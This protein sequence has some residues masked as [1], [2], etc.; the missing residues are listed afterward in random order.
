MLHCE[1]DPTLK[2]CTIRACEIEQLDV[3]S[4][5]NS[6]FLIWMIF[7]RD[8]IVNLWA[9]SFMVE[10]IN[11]SSTPCVPMNSHEFHI[12]A[13]V[14]QRSRLMCNALVG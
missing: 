8:F 12:Y 14:L 13:Y 11:F 4:V 1:M 10:R 5:K 2:I 9:S 3:G 6:R 7:V